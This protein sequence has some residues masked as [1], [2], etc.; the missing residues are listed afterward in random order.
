M[1]GGDNLVLN[2]FRLAGRR[3][4]WG[5]EERSGGDGIKAFIEICGRCTDL[6]GL[7]SLTHELFVKLKSSPER[8]LGWRYIAKDRQCCLRVLFTRILA[9]LIF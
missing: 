6:S 8:I 2:R 7:I 5:N 3:C 9:W 1:Q 4:R